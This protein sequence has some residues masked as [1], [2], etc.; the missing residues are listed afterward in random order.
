MNPKF[1]YVPKQFYWILLNYVNGT[2]EL[3]LLSKAP[4][5]C[6]LGSCDIVI[7]LLYLIIN[8]IIHIFLLILSISKLT[9]YSKLL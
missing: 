1:S 2:I 6:A 5:V 9:A 3:T 7:Y 4:T 8:N